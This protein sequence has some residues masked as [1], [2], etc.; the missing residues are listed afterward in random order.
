MT[1]NSLHQITHHQSNNLSTLLLYSQ[2]QNKSF[3]TMTNKTT[4]TATVFLSLSALASFKYL[5]YTANSCGMDL[6]KISIQEVVL[7]RDAYLLGQPL[8]HNPN[9]TKQQPCIT[10]DGT[11]SNHFWSV[12]LLPF[13]VR[14]YPPYVCTPRTTNASMLLTFL[15]QQKWIFF[16]QSF[17]KSEIPSRFSHFVA[18]VFALCCCNAKTTVRQIC[19]CY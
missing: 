4:I 11:L 12:W 7:V 14:L 10:P 17:S 1:P 3:A 19:C 8:T 16:W 2:H 18:V 13:A 15:R 9:R 6:P 5:V